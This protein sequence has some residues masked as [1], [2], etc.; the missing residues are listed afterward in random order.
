MAKKKKAYKKITAKQISKIAVSEKSWN[1][2]LES[3]RYSV[4]VMRVDRYDVNYL[5]ELFQ[6]RLMMLGFSVSN[7]NN[8]FR[9]Y[10]VSWDQEPSIKEYD[11]MIREL[12]KKRDDLKKEKLIKKMSGIR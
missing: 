9:N 2:L 7:N 5:P 3:I 10:T 8:A 6:T 4:E 1:S 12:T 11:G